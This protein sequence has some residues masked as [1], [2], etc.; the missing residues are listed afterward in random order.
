MLCLVIIQIVSVQY[1][2]M[3]LVYAM[4]AENVVVNPKIYLVVVT[5]KKI[6]LIT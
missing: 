1:A 3:M 2:L 6:N 5:S 4:I